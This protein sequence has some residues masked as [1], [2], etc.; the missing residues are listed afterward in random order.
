[1]SKSF[2]GTFECDSCSHKEKRGC[3]GCSAENQARV[4]R[5]E[6]A[7]GVYTCA[8]D[9]KDTQCRKC[10]DSVCPF[11][12]NPEKVGPV[13]AQFEKKRCYMKKLSEHFVGNSLPGSHSLDIKVPEKTIDRL[14]S[15]VIVLDELMQLGISQVS[16][17]DLS[18]KTGVR[19]YLIR[20]DLSLFGEFGRPSIGY[21][22]KNLRQA[23]SE[24][25]NL[26]RDKKVVW[27]G[28]LHLAA[29][30]SLKQQ[31]ENY[32][33]RIVAIVDPRPEIFGGRIGDMEIGHISM[34]TDTV[35]KTAARGAIISTPKDMAQ[36]VADA[37]VRA[38]VDGI[39]NLSPVGITA[40]ERVCVRN[41][42]IVS[43]LLSMAY[44]CEKVREARTDT[45][46]A[47]QP[48]A[49]RPL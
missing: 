12:R 42:N 6:K 34:L 19:D 5:N 11:I 21:S 31:F 30:P 1:M 43:E 40:P 3:L 33:V 44:Y 10:V 4:E 25:L 35:R 27:V 14:Q 41:V 18:R 36:D 26:E 47:P 48:F 28:A 32:N 24:I 7:C 23:I 9:R 39:L 22:T 45:T 13:R 2:C 15:Y 49:Q 37:L 20:R 38:G 8:V 29:D 17:A 16:S 46:A